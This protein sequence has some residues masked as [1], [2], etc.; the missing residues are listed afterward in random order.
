MRIDESSSLEFYLVSIC[1]SLWRSKK[2]CR[3]LDLIEQ[4]INCEKPVKSHR[5]IN[6]CSTKVNEKT[7]LQNRKRK[8]L[9]PYFS[10]SKI[11]KHTNTRQR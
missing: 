2:N 1:I 3:K 4:F 9:T 8:I 7:E 11:K 10:L 6:L 5:R